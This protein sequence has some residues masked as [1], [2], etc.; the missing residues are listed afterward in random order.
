MLNIKID[1]QGLEEL[2]KYIKFVEQMAKMKTDKKF[3]KFIQQK[4]LETVN[5]IT[6]ER[7]VGGTT[8]DSA[9]SLY[10]ESNKIREYEEGFILYNDASITVNAKD[11]SSYPNGEFSVAL[12]FEYGVGIIGQNTPNNEG[13]WAYN[14]NNYNFGW[15]FKSEEDDKYYETAGYMGFEIYRYTAIECQSKLKDWVKEYYDREVQ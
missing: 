13:A 6:N 5:K 2:Q 8:N 12:A 10:K 4:V 14:V 3:Q 7:L 9:I 15:W 11:T 1:T